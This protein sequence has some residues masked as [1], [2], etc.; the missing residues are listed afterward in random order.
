MKGNIGALNLKKVLADCDIAQRELAR[1]IGWSGTT[2]NY[3]VNRGIFPKK[4]PKILM[5]IIEEYLVKT[6]KFAI[7]LE[8]LELNQSE[9]WQPMKNQLAA[10]NIKL[11][12]ES[13]GKRIY[14]T[15]NKPVWKKGDPTQIAPQ[16][17]TMLTREAM[18]EFKLFKNPFVG[19]INSIKDIYLGTD[20][21]YIRETMI[22]AAKNGGFVA[23]YGEVGSGKSTMRKAVVELLQLDGIKVIFP[24][25][26]DKSRISPASL[27][28]AIIMDISEESPKRSLEAKTRQAL[29]LLRNRAAAGMKQVLM[30]E[31]AHLLN[32]GA[33]KALKQIYELEEGF[34]KLISIVLIGQ[35]ELQYRLDEAT[36]PELREVIRR[37]VVAE[38]KGVNGKV[39]EYLTH[40]FKSCGVKLEQIF[41]G[42][43]VYA[44]IENRL[45][46][47][48]PLSVNNLVARAIN[49]AAEIGEE[50]VTVD[51]IL[52]C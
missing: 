6:P 34:R 12:P 44:A 48:Y 15:R 51:V 52:S 4:R 32:I 27:I 30:I 21:I 24:V 26:I 28:D 36:F 11:S 43:D 45:A 19:D 17:V 18:K 13:R 20:H 38:I 8:S 42:D 2:I 9:I 3:I 33:F 22:M 41:S 46:G 25:I 23:V 49:T 31:E 5:Q 35:S 50:R 16:E 1:E 37:C 47:A 7:V 40:K 10:K 29:R 14:K 39:K